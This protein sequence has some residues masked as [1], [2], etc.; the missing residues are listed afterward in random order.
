MNN[1]FTKSSGEPIFGESIRMRQEIGIGARRA[2]GRSQQLSGNH[3]ATEDE[4]AR[5]MRTYSNSRRSTFPEA[6]GSPGCLRSSACTPVNS[7]VLTICSPSA[8]RRGA[9]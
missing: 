5:T 6:N 9:S 8:A 1:R 4:G 3:I 2:T 7:S